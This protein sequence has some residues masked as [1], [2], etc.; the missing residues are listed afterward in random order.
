MNHHQILN[1]S[2]MYHDNYYFKIFPYYIFYF[3]YYYQHFKIKDYCKIFY[4]LYSFF[5]YQNNNLIS[6]FVSIKIRNTLKHSKL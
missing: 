6:N 5:D 4:N 1:F 2:I 3:T